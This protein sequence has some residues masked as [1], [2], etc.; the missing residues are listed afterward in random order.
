[1]CCGVEGTCVSATLLAASALPEVKIGPGW[2]SMGLLCWLRSERCD[3]CVRSERHPTGASSY[4]VPE[5]LNSTEQRG[6]K[7]MTPRKSMKRD[8]LEDFHHA[9]NKLVTRGCGQD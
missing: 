9:V 6:R 4:S 8:E 7:I 3:L 2:L 5:S 1:M